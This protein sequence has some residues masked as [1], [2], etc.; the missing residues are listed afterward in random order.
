M[1]VCLCG[2]AAVG[3][4]VAQR[5]HVGAAVKTGTCDEGGQLQG[6]VGRVSQLLWDDLHV[7]HVQKG[8]WNIIREGRERRRRGRG[9]QAGDVPR[10]DAAPT[11]AALQRRRW[12]P[13]S[14]PAASDSPDASAEMEAA[15]TP[16]ARS[17]TM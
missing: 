2:A 10:R 13:A 6:H 12:Q 16:F 15:P 14:Q 4:R 1:S 8:A 3:E 9:C 11:L 17:L 5:P 7:G